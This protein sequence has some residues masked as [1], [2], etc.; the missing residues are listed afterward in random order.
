MSREDYHKANDDNLARLA[1]YLDVKVSS[2]W[3]HKH[4]ADK[5]YYAVLKVYK[6][7]S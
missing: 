5:V 3:R 1:K 7:V 2:A 4:L 6:D